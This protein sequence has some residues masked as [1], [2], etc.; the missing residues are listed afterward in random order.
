MRDVKSN[1]LIFKNENEKVRVIIMSMRKSEKI[2]IREVNMKR[3]FFHTVKEKGLMFVLY[4]MYAIGWVLEEELIEIERVVKPSGHAIHLLIGPK[5]E[6]NPFHQ[7]LTS[8][9]WNYLMKE[10]ASN[11]DEEIKIKYWKQ[12]APVSEL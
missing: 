1:S 12:I 11:S 9:K 2:D 7:T 8:S 3:E 5:S 10:V 4:L 6:L